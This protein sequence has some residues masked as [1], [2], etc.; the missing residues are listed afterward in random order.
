MY[1][2]VLKGVNTDWLSQPVRTGVGQKYNLRLEGGDQAFRW[3][4]DLSYNSI[5]GAMKGSK[6]NTFSGSVTLSYSVK[7]V[8]FKNQT[9]VDINKGD[10]SKYGT[11]SDYAEMNPY[12]RIKDENGVM[13]QS[14]TR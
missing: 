13:Y 1:E 4:V 5:M 3:G 8:I 7:N 12:Y 11:F 10:E 2:E 6:R 9:G 14:T